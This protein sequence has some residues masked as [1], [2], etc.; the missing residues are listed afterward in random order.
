M[1]R[2]SGYA[3]LA[4]GE[5]CERPG[6]STEQA[7]GRSGGSG[8]GRLPEP[9]RSRAYE[10]KWRTGSGHEPPSTKSTAIILCLS[11]SGASPCT[12]CFM[13][14]ASRSF[15]SGWNGSR[16]GAHLLRHKGMRSNIGLKHSQRGV[17]SYRRTAWLKPDVRRT[18]G[19]TL[20]QAMD[21]KLWHLS[22]RRP[23]FLA[24]VCGLPACGRS[25]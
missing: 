16:S 23:L 25:R 9:L 21:A 17:Q 19:S 3:R 22:R 20:Q 5:V 12:I 8:G 4:D 13:H 24:L 2:H 18:K 15:F 11:C 1:A 10:R 14:T 6:S 7:S